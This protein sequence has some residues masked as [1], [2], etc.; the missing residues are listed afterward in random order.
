MYNLF[1]CYVSVHLIVLNTFLSHIY[2]VTRFF[3]I[4]HYVIY[5]SVL[6]VFSFFGS[7]LWFQKFSSK[8]H[9]RQE[10][11]REVHQNKDNPSEGSKVKS[12]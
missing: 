12:V 8:P 11:S 4:P 5:C 3:K 10:M 9:M 7:F 6:S 2:I 1:K